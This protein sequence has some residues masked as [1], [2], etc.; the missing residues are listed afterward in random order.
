MKFYSFEYSTKELKKYS[1]LKSKNVLVT[2]FCGIPNKIYIL[3]LINEIKSFF[4]NAKII[5]TTTDGEINNSNISSGLS[6]I[7]LY[8]FENTS[9]KTALFPF[10]DD[11]F[12]LGKNIVKKMHTGSTKLSLIFASGS[13]FY[14]K[15][16]EGID[17][18][19]N[20]V[21][22]LG[23]VAGDNFK[24]KKSFVFT[25]EGILSEGVGVVSF[26]SEVLEVGMDYTF[27]W[28]GIG[29]ELKVTKAKDNI[30]YEIDN[31]PAIDVYKHYFGNIE[32]K[33]IETGLEIPLIKKHKDIYVARALM[34][35]KDKGLVFGGGF[36]VNDIVKFGISDKYLAMQEAKDKFSKLL[37]NNI[38]ALMIFS[39]VS[40]RRS[41]FNIS[42]DEILMLKNIPNIGFFGYGEFFGDKFLNQTTVV[43]SLSEGGD[44]L[45][46]KLYFRDSTDFFHGLVHLINMALNETDKKLYFDELTGV[47]SKFAF[48]KEVIKN[49]YGGVLFDISKFSSLND[50]YGE[51][52]GDEI[53]RAFANYLNSVIPEV[54]KVFRIS[55][56]NFFV[57]FFEEFNLL[58]FANRVIEHFYN[59]PLSIKINNEEIKIDLDLIAAVVEKEDN[60]KIKADLA[61]HYAKAHKISIIKYSKN[62]GIEE[63]I[64]K[65]LKTI[66]FVKKALKNNKIVPVYQ[67]IEKSTPSYEALVRIED[68]GKLISPFEFLDSI[69]DTRYY[70]IMTKTMIN[71]VFE[72]MKDKDVNVSINLSYKDIRNSSTINYLI[73]MIQKYRMYNR[74]T[75]ELLETESIVDFKN[76][77]EFVY[78]MKRYN[79]KI[80]ID[81]FGS[82]YSNFVYLTEL[83]PDFIKIDGSLIKNIEKSQNQ[84]IVKAIVN[85][86]KSLGIETIAEFV[87]SQ[88]VYNIC[89]NLGIDGFQGYF[90]H[91]PSKEIS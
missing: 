21:P 88:K 53:L 41:V 49:P 19:N 54:A 51:D 84:K 3:S 72:Y 5:G 85:F 18:M 57:L 68:K 7:G 27:S 42:K 63:K 2:V 83:R 78:E 13:A 24:F 14:E 69:K 26:D 38:E 10:S 89:K 28:R 59:Y 75:V 46:K 17:F 29:K 91:M 77:K 61:L 39:C 1:F 58:E 80:A 62:L 40:R 82:G 45:S 81:D 70:H 25:E 90:I 11:L 37:K 22:V 64:E 35:V 71:K 67:K 86:A 32:D 87:C 52:V 34:G 48:E 23:S 33:I 36:R 6:V 65:E 66:S 4:P 31:M 44:V 43:L 56:D 47:G 76:V 8:F 20:N 79:V 15:L 55:G 50:K 73:S 12:E 16:I 74:L 9:V 60:L 30:V